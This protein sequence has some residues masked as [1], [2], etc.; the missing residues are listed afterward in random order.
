MGERTT[1]C[2]SDS[3]KFGSWAQNVMTEWHIRY[4]GRGV[5]IYWHV[6]KKSTCIYSLLKR[7]SSSE[8]AAMIE[9]VL[10][11]CTDMD[12]EKQYVDSH[13]QSEVAFAFSYLLGFDLLPQP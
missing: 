5:M 1:S 3:K 11:H 13:G 12:I 2:A 9:G 10:R 7:C 8:V 4:G 6:E